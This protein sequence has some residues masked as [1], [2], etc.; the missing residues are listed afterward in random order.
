MTEMLLIFGFLLLQLRNLP[1]LLLH[2]TTQLLL[3]LEMSVTL[4]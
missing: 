3:W 1:L 2:K 4:L